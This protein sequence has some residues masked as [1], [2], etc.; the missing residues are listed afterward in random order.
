M[1]ED[2]GRC[3]GAAAEA[4]ERL[5]QQHKAE[6]EL[7]RREVDGE[8]NVLA[9]KNAALERIVKEQAEQVARLQEQAE[10]AYAQVQEIAVRA[11]EGSANG[12][13]TH[14]ESHTVSL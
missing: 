1:P 14:A 3:V 11:I 9:T 6:L 5:K 4:T 7:L 13:R 12:H 8:K 2:G 10:K